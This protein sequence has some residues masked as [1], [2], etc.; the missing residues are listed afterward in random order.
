MTERHNDTLLEQ[1]IDTCRVLTGSQAEDTVYAEKC[2]RRYVIPAADLE[3]AQRTLTL[4]LRSTPSPD[5]CYRV[6]AT[7]ARD[8]V[9]DELPDMVRTRLDDLRHSSEAM[10]EVFIQTNDTTEID[11]A[12]PV[13]AEDGYR[14]VQKLTFEIDPIERTMAQSVSEVYTE[15]KVELVLAQFDNMTDH[16]QSDEFLDIVSGVQQEQQQEYYAQCLGALALL[17]STASVQDISLRL[18]PYQR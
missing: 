12:A 9:Y 7:L 1:T 15:G 16:E 13:I 2:S 10:R 11:G 18:F 5:E 4:T 17:Q 8:L 6:K 14:Y 3:G